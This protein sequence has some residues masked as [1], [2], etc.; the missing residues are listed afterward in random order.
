MKSTSRKAIIRISLLM[1]FTL[2]ASGTMMFIF[3]G[4]NDS[5]EARL[6][7]MN[8]T[9][10]SNV[11]RG[12]RTVTAGNALVI[13]G[14]GRV[15]GNISVMPG[16]L[17]VVQGNVNADRAVQGRV[18]LNGGDFYL[19]SGNIWNTAGAQSPA[20]AINNGSNFTMQGGN[21]RATMH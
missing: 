3:A 7:N 12:A 9:T 4:N 16:A 19:V 18:L 15:E 17:L 13:T 6:A 8:V 1:V 14:A 5:L 2:I 11:A 21:I 10:I 20:V